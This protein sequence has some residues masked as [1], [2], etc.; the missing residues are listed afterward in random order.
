MKMYKPDSLQETLSL[1]AK[2]PGRKMLLA[3]GSDI[4]ILIKLGKLK[5]ESIIFINHLPELHGVDMCSTKLIIGAA[6]TISE[7]SGSSVIRQYCPFLADSMKDFASPPIAN[8]ATLAGNIANS[9]PTADTVPLLLVLDAKLVIKSLT[10]TRM[11]P[12]YDFYTGYKQTRLQDDELI[13][14]IEIPLKFACKYQPQYIK[15]GSR[16]ALTIAKVALAFVKYENKFRIAAGSLNEYPRRLYSVEEY[17]SAHP[18]DYNDNDLMSTLK[19]DITPIT[20]FRSD[21][22]YRLQVCFNYLRKFIKSA[23]SD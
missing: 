3:G 18:D 17:F 19:K 14:A 6:T 10:T 7:I 8:F 5:D 22:E 21:K 16:T 23:N 4:N 2:L 1:L 11:L 9:S 12:L 20:D 15:I 13:I